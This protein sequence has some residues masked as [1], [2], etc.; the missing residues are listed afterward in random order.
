MRIPMTIRAQCPGSIRALLRIGRVLKSSSSWWSCL[1]VILIAG[2]LWRCRASVEQDGKPWI[3]DPDTVH[4]VARLVALEHATRYPLVDAR[5]GFPGSVESHWTRPMDWVVMAL[6]PIGRTIWP[7]ARPYEAGALLAGPTLAMLTALLV[8]LYARRLFSPFAGLAAAAFYAASYS[9]ISVSWLGNGDH[10]T[11]QALAVTGALGAFLVALANPGTVRSALVSGVWLG[12]AV[13]VSAESMLVVYLVG[14]AAFVLAWRERGGGAGLRRALQAL[15]TGLGTVVLVATFVEQRDDPWR[16]VWDSVSLFHLWQV[17]VLTAFSLFLAWPLRGR[18]RALI[19]A[20]LGIVV[21]GL[22]FVFGPLREA[23]WTSLQQVAGTDLWGKHEVSEYRSALWTGFGFSFWKLVERFSWF[24]VVLPF[25]AL[26]YVRLATTPKAL[27]YALVFFAF[28]TLGLAVHEVKL[29][30]LHAAP[31]AWL[32]VAAGTA[33]VAA[34][35]TLRPVCALAT[36]LAAV[37]LAFAQPVPNGRGATDEGR[38][39]VLAE[40]CTDVD[41]LVGQNPTGA[42]LAPW[43]QGAHLHCLSHANVVASGYHRNLE[44]IKDAYRVY[45]AKAGDEATWRPILAARKVTHV[46]VWPDRHFFATAP[47]VLGDAT[48]FVK[49]SDGRME[50][51]PPATASLYWTLRRGGPKI[52]AGFT[53]AAK[54]SGEI[55]VGFGPEPAFTIWAISR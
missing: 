19:A 39:K 34:R 23:V 43:S 9:T 5:E 51:Y 37:G 8:G 25:V 6:D 46:V 26:A 24:P 1:L 14:L 48:E 27:R 30:H 20:G 7:A 31:A 13:W 10:Q 33:A 52:P 29:A 53:L 22:P 49:V 15:C 40:L 4:R 17:L 41:R 36:L 28:G 54:S 42:V 45:L 21:G 3:D 2:F 44:G 32:L 55:D 38:R 16:L 18:K 35:P 50:M 47:K 12:C 11:L